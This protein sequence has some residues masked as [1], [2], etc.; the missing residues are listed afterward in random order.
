MLAGLS[1]VDTAKVFIC[2]HDCLY[3]PEYF[4][5]ETDEPVSYS[6]N[7]EYLT[8]RGFVFRT[9][10]DKG[11][12]STLYGS[13]DVI[14]QEVKE[15][16]REAQA[17]Q[18]KWAEPRNGVPLRRQSPRIVDIRHGSNFTKGRTGRYYDMQRAKTLWEGIAND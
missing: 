17:G 18:V 14:T 13:T 4:N 2:E 7:V 3:P 6:A 12:L 9:N 1:K 10:G 15:K 16:L 11:P 8:R 5:I